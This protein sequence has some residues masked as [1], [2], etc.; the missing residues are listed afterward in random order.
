[1][2]CALPRSGTKVLVPAGAG[3]F[4]GR[5]RLGAME[6]GCSV[7]SWVAFPAVKAPL[8]SY[9]LCFRDQQD[10]SVCSNVKCY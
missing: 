4:M 2:N 9:R 5:H 8:L 1:M 7:L 3:L 6:D 10:M